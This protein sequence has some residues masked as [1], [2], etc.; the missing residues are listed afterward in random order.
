MPGK[1]VPGTSEPREGCAKC[2]GTPL[3]GVP[4]KLWG[5]E[6]GSRFQSEQTKQGIGSYFFTLENFGVELGYFGQIWPQTLQ[7]KFRL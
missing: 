2:A 4:R 7:N 1:G 5:E 6:A 3:K